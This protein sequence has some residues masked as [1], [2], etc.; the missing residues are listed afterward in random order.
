MTAPYDYHLNFEAL[1]R[2]TEELE[3]LLNK[4]RSENKYVEE[5]YQSLKPLFDKI[6]SNQLK[7]AIDGNLSVSRMLGESGVEIE[8]PDLSQAYAVFSLDVKGLT[9]DPFNEVF[10]KMY[11]KAKAKAF[12]EQ[13][14][15]Q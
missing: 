4:Y 9:D 8:Y 1:H 15:N 14:E 10:K 7:K 12:A 13:K 6:H 2:S 3:R 11:E 5:A